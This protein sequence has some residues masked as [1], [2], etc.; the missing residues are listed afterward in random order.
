MS[1]EGD[2]GL[3]AAI[4]DGF[5]ERKEFLYVNTLGAKNSYIICQAISICVKIPSP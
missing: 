5:V 4:W 3:R 1:S 2:V